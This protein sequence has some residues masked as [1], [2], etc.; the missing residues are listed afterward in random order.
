MYSAHVARARRCE[1]MHG[2][3]GEVQLARNCHMPEEA[4][5][6]FTR[7]RIRDCKRAHIVELDRVFPSSFSAWFAARQCSTNLARAVY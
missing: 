3:P 5:L 6:L 7:L 1:L 4:R 2:E